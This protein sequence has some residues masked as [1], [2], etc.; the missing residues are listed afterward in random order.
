MPDIQRPRYLKRA[1]AAAYLCIS[2]P[3][4][5]RWASH[6]IGPRYYLL[7]RN[8]RYV[9]EDLDSFIEGRRSDRGQDNHVADLRN[10]HP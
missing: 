9:Q 8:A 10:Q 5:A 1:E 6:N 3:T 2:V 7:G 4:L